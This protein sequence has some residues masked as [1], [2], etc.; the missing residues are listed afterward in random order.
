M[1]KARNKEAGETSTSKTIGKALGGGRLSEGEMTGSGTIVVIIERVRVTIDW[2]INITIEG[3]I[4]ARNLF[5]LPL[6]DEV[7]RRR[8]ESKFANIS[9]IAWSGNWS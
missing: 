5:M 2:M 8:K 6:L 1:V 9:N 4:L 3:G 7:T